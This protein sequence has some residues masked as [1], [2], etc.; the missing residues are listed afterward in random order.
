MK[1]EKP[2][3]STDKHDRGPI[4]ATGG[5]SKNIVSSQSYNFLKITICL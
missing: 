4:K 1:T 2:N 5:G 3:H